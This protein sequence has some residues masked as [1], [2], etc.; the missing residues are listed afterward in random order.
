ME[1]YKELV[2]KSKVEK[3]EVY[4]NFQRKCTSDLSKLKIPKKFR[5]DI[6]DPESE[7]NAFNYN[8]GFFTTARIFYK[9][10]IVGLVSPD[11]SQGLSNIK[12]ESLHLQ[13]YGIF[14]NFLDSFNYI[15]EINNVDRL[16]RNKDINTLQESLDFL[17]ILRITMS[18]NI[19]EFLK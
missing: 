3:L 19:K 4:K 11:F 9:N 2:E 5:I 12:I 17:E 6:L 16:S 13:V 10:E 1:K 18:D 14:N 8:R 15:N 7:D